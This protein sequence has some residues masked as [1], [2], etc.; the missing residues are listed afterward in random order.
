L[1]IFEW[2]GSLYPNEYIVLTAH[3]DSLDVG[4]G[5]IDD[6]GG[7]A[8]AWHAL[9][10]LKN[11][12]FQPKRTIRIVFWAGEEIGSKGVKY[13]FQQHK[14][15]T[16]KWI[17]AYES[18]QGAFMPSGPA[19]NTYFEVQGNATAVQRLQVLIFSVYPP[20]IFLLWKYLTNTIHHML[21]RNY[22]QRSYN[23]PYLAE[24]LF[25]FFISPYH[26]NHLIAV[27]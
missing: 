8:V 13:Y 27:L 6:G 19:N 1:H 17:F 15:S 16:E 10:T 24:V 3:F 20:F 21:Q 26:V 14:N 12:G 4:Q 18:D 11:L 2:T 23:I 22:Y 5:A 7:C 25:T 9:T